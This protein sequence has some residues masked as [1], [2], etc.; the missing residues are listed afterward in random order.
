M[1][2]QPDRQGIYE[3]TFT[4]LETEE[5]T[6][7]TGGVIPWHGSDTVGNPK[8]IS[9]ICGKQGNAKFT[10]RIWDKENATLIAKKSNKSNQW[11]HLLDLGTITNVTEGASIWEVQIKKTEGDE[12]RAVSVATVVMEF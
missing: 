1:S 11:P 9:V 10:V 5:S 8:K 2:A 12:G 3:Y 7:E 6:F 4:K